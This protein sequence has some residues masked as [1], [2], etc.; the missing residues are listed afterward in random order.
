MTLFS[1]WGHSHDQH[2]IFDS[3][4]GNILITLRLLIA[5]VFLVGC[6]LT[7][8][9]VRHSLKRFINSLTLLGGLYILSLPVIVLAA[10]AYLL[11]KNRNEFVFIT[12]EVVKFT[13]NLVLNYEYSSKDSEY[14][15]VNYKNASFIP[16]DEKGLR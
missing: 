1:K 4:G 14:N 9:S 7:R 13:T 15:R 5:V 10:N 12:V 8:K 16:D 6:C 3:L 11:P 2:H